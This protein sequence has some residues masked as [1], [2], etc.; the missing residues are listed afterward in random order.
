MSELQQIHPSPGLDPGWHWDLQC[1]A[2]FQHK[3]FTVNVLVR[4]ATAE[5]GAYYLGTE[6][7]TNDVVIVGTVT[8][9]S[10]ELSSA[11]HGADITE[12]HHMREALDHVLD[13]AVSD[14]R[15]QVARLVELLAD[16]DVKQAPTLGETRR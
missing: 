10:R 9:D 8:L 16:I 13:A 11:E 6:P 1:R 5:D 2:R 7:S 3:G 14:A 15:R 12:P 4:P